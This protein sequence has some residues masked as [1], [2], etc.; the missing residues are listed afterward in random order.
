MGRGRKW[1]SREIVSAAERKWHF[2]RK[3]VFARFSPIWIKRYRINAKGNFINLRSFTPFLPWNG[4]HLGNSKRCQEWLQISDAPF[5]SR[6]FWPTRPVR[7]VSLNMGG[8]AALRRVM[9]ASLWSGRE[10]ETKKCQI[11]ERDFRKSIDNFIILFHF[12]FNWPSYCKG[13]SIY[14]RPIL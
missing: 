8:I 4:R 6:I 12:P 10:G 1:V 14:I 2:V 7:F 5:V 9:R 13:V 11:G 3:T